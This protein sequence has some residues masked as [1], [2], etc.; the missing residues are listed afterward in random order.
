MK[1]VCVFLP[2][3][4]MVPPLPLPFPLCLQY[5]N[6]LILRGHELYGRAQNAIDTR[7]A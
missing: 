4:F 2:L 6:L 5:L 7:S 3:H 1:I